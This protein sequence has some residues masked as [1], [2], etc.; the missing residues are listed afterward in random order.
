M[1]SGEFEQA[2]PAGKE[3][4]RQIEAFWYASVIEV[5]TAC[6]HLKLQLG[7]GFCIFVVRL[8]RSHLLASWFILL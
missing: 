7:A 2:V 3:I 8:E 5:C 1:M 6:L 4:G